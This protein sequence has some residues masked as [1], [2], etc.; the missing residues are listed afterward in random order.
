MTPVALTIAGSDPS[1]G[2]GVQAD[3]KTFHQHRV[4]GT[5]VITLLTVQNTRSVDAVQHLDPD[6][7]IAQLDAVL[8][9]IPPQAAKTGALGSA[10]I[11]QALAERAP[12]FS[13]PLVID[14]IMISKHGVALLDNDAVELLKNKLLPQAFLVTPNLAEATALAEM[15]VVDRPSMEKAAR[16]IAQLGPRNVLIKGGHLQETADGLQ[17]HRAVPTYVGIRERNPAQ[18]AAGFSPR[19]PSK[20]GAAGFSPRDASK[21]GAAG[22]SP[23]DASKKGAAG[24]SP[25]DASKISETASCSTAQHALDVLCSDGEIHL[26]T[27][28][29]VENRSTHGTGCVFSAAIT[30]RLARG[31]PLTEAVRKAK[32]FITRAIRTSP[33]LGGGVSPTNIHADIPP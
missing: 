9:D 10:A 13:F 15:E 22:F 2:A 26:F 17:S 11:V 20:K 7:V 14:P 12:R 3:L 1:G 19:N 29:P 32:D 8:D 23:R 25:R 5:S 21:K 31:E 27:A 6:F 4:Y 24:F 30:A 18:G 16:A 28:E 33:A